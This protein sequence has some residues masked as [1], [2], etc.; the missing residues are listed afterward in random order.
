M[1][2]GTLNGESRFPKVQNLRAYWVGVMEGGTRRNKLASG[3]SSN[4]MKRPQQHGLDRK[5]ISSNYFSMESFL[6]LICLTASLLILPLI[7]PPLPPPPFLLLLLPI[8]ILLVLIVLAF[9]PSDIRNIASSYLWR[10]FILLQDE[11][12][13]FLYL[14]LNDKID[15]YKIKSFWHSASFPA[16]MVVITCP[17]NKIT[18]ILINLQF[19]VWWIQTI[20]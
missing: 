10:S 3:S 6:V 15:T 5:A 7:L 20:S 14:F 17:W 19:T 12:N 11:W 4:N 9:M 8:C 16:K 18:W 2:F 13:V 1:Y